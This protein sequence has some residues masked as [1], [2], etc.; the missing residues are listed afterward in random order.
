MR[1]HPSP[2]PQVRPL[3]WLLALAA[4]AVASALALA[5]AAHWSV[6]GLAMLYLLAVVIAAVWLPPRPAALAS[7]AS[8]AALNW[9][10]VPPQRSFAVQSAEGWWL[11]AVLLAT[12]LGLQAVMAQLRRERSEARAA[13]ARALQARTLMQ[14][15]AACDGPADV[16]QALVDTLARLAGAPAAVFVRD[17]HNAS[18]PLARQASDTQATFDADA[19][20]WVIETGRPAGRGC[21]D[22]PDLRLWCAPFSRRG[23]G[24]VQLSLPDDGTPDP[25]TAAH[26]QDLVR[27]GG[28]AIERERDA[29][30][31]READ[32]AA[33][34]QAARNTLLASLS[35]DL[36]T[37]LAAL[38]GSASALRAQGQA[39]SA[40]QRERLLAALE[41]EALDLAAM[42]ENVLQAARLAQPE[43]SPRMDWES[44]AD[45]LGAAVSRMRRRWPAA[46][47]QLRCPPDLP[48]LRAEAALLAQAVA[49]LVDNAARHGGPQ[50]RIVVQAGRS[51]DGLFV[52]VRDHGPGLPPGDAC[53]LFER[54]QAGSGSAGGTGL[55]LAIVRLAA[56]AHGGRV[57]ARNAE[58]GAE[59]RIDLPLQPAPAEIAE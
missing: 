49:N 4:P 43:A 21:P 41:D 27:L 36:R 13:Q 39:M 38:V 34:S 33:R 23:Q 24:A 17:P 7:L 15:L 42:A 35:H 31:A 14:Q 1:P 3:A 22:W 52:A 32:Q 56:Q 25:A 26:W 44:L 53:A 55:G 8:V 57:G 2:E 28:A 47:I 19:A 58:P 29:V 45:V 48:P 46:G 10:F 11:L 54:W 20:R 18:A 50:A 30:R 12:A 51:R 37:P 9:L 5:L 6:A 16:T 59:F 40:A